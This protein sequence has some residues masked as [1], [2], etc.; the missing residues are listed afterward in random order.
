MSGQND[1]LI[2]HDLR[3]QKTK[4]EIKK[5][6]EEIENQENLEKEKRV[7]QV[8]I[9][10]KI[11]YIIFAAFMIFGVF[12]YFIEESDDN[13]TYSGCN[14]PVYSYE[15]NL[16][17]YCEKHRLEYENYEWS[18]DTKKYFDSNK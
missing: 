7:R 5:R 9:I 10:K 2:K 13:C 8:Y 1:W 3:L 14:N 16:N 15:D 6:E 12:L 17:G 18:Q 4:E 11:G